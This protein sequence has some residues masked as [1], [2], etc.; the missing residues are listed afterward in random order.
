MDTSR[1]TA[2]LVCPEGATRVDTG[3][4]PLEGVVDH[5]CSIIAGTEI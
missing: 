5:L 3:P 2:P 1:K 4:L